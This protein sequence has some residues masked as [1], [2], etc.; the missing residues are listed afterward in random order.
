MHPCSLR[1]GIKRR[2][3]P[4]HARTD[5]IFVLRAAQRDSS[6]PHS[7]LF[8]FCNGKVSNR[9]LLS[10]LCGLCVRGMCAFGACVRSVH[11]CVGAR[12]RGSGRGWQDRALSLG[13]KVLVEQALRVEKFQAHMG[14]QNMGKLALDKLSA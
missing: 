7:G 8:V 5:G 3:A 1:R 2:A 6:V 9:N 11:A 14:L 12:R 13:L 10:G 4:A